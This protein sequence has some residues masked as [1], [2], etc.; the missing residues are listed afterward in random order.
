MNVLKDDSRV[1]A[2]GW[3][4]PAKTE[5]PNQ[6]SPTE[7]SVPVPVYCRPLSDYENDYKVSCASAVNLDCGNIKNLRDTIQQCCYFNEKRS[8]DNFSTSFIWLCNVN[9]NSTRIYVMD[10]NRPVRFCVFIYFF[11][12]LIT[13]G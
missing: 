10:A 11:A 6:K 12:E 8:A 9:S 5:L 4:L 1:Q 13:L 2:Y 7:I 3:S